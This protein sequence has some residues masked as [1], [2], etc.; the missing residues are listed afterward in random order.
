MLVDITNPAQKQ[1][2]FLRRTFEQGKLGHSYLFID[3]NEQEAVNTAYW[4]ACLSNCTGMEKPDGTCK[5]CQQIISGNHPDVLLIEPENKQS[6]SIDQI[7][8]LKEELAKSPV[9]SPI[10]FFFINQAEKLS[11]PAANALLNLLEEPIAPVV[12]IL[13]ANNVNQILPTIK[14]RTQIINFVPNS[15][16]TDRNEKLIEQGFSQNELEELDDTTNLAKLGK[17]FYEEMVEQN[18]LALVSAHQLA[19]TVK[20]RAKQDYLLFLLKDLAQKDIDSGNL[21]SGG[22][23]LKDLLKIDQMRCSNVN[24]R[25]LLDYLALQWKR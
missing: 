10:R 6:L 20:S 19:D 24:F 14:S 8:F 23:M 7:R 17:Y 1:V 11:L 5:N 9:Q 21:Q 18:P 3:I 4:L 15:Q 13:I 2:A 12:T 16:N 22:K 25:N